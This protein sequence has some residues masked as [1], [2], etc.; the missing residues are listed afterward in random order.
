[1]DD[2]NLTVVCCYNKRELYETMLGTLKNAETKFNVIGIDNTNNR[3]TS[4]AVALNSAVSEVKTD[5]VI[6]AHQDVY[7][8]SP[9]EFDIFAERLFETGE[10][11]IM[12]VAGVMN[13]VRGR[14]TNIYR[15]FSGDYALKD[16]A[17]LLM[18][19][20]TLDECFFGGR[21]ELFR[22][23]PFDEELC[24]GWHLYCADRC[25]DIK[26]KGGHVWICGITMFH[27]SDG[28]IDRSFINTFM[29][30]ARKY[31]GDYRTI[32]TCCSSCR[33]GAGKEISLIKME[34]LRLRLKLKRR[35]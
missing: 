29:R 5:F 4:C 7:F 28:V 24:N 1:M 35:A 21:T 2:I 18:E 26:R 9:S 30:T 20:D 3:F 34:L 25:L 16:R 8:Q 11:D 10:R 31:R 22:K 32:R 12:G 13:E 19:C 23:F 6:F 15:S 27:P 14:Y 17:E 33:T